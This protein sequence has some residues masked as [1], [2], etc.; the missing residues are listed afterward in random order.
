[1]ATP[2]AQDLKERITFK[3]VTAP[4]NAASRVGSNPV[5]VITVRASVEEQGGEF[6][7]VHQKSMI[8]IK[9]YEIWTQYQSVINGFQQIEWGDKMLVQIT[10]PQKIVDR[11]GRAW[12]CI[13]AK[14]TIAHNL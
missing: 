5:T 2:I 8:L 14:E 7:V 11:R 6:G 12:L 10:P 9:E 13:R 4:F 3:N 1:M